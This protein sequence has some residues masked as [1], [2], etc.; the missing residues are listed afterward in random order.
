VTRL[1]QVFR[2]IGEKP[3]GKKCDGMMGIIEEGIR[4]A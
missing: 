3:R 4:R 1:E 2:A